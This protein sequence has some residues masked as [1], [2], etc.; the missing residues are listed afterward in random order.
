MKAFVKSLLY[1]AFG[2]VKGNLEKGE[3]SLQNCISEEQELKAVL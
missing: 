2:T 3:F 1:L